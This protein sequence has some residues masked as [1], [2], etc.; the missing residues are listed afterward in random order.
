[1]TDEKTTIHPILLSAI[2]DM[3][4][5]QLYELTRG[6]MLSDVDKQTLLNLL[7]DELDR[8]KKL[9]LDSGTLFPA[10]AQE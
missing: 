3:S 4:S 5:G 7:F 2:A 10:L 6:L 1:M 9:A 8:R